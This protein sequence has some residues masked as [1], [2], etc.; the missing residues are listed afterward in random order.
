[1]EV[2]PGGLLLAPGHRRGLHAGVHPGGPG[3]PAVQAPGLLQEP[4]H[5]HRRHP[6]HHRFDPAMRMLFA[7]MDPFTFRPRWLSWLRHPGAGRAVLPRGEASRSAAL[8]HRLYEPPCRFV[9]RHAKA[10][11]RRGGAD[12]RG[13][14]SRSICSWARS[15]CRRLSE[16]TLLYMPST[17][18][19]ISRDRGP[20]H[21]QVQD[22][23]MRT[24]PGSGPGVRQ[25]RAGRYGHRPGAL[26]H[27]GDRDR[28]QARGP[29]A[30]ARRAGTP[31]GPPAG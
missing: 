5:G 6:G 9:L 10:H 18:P 24:V 20:A 12:G 31:P 26:L 8:L 22:Q 16:G 14:P 7:R 19:G 29:V 2:G 4:R 21:L 3:R 17:L 13:R 23:L 15:S 28:A 1:M 30:H 25:G 11:H 27:D